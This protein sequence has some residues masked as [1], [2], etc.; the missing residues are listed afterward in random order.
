M[1]EAKRNEVV[2]E[3]AGFKIHQR[4]EYI[5][6]KGF[7]DFDHGWDYPDGSWHSLLPDLL[8]DLNALFKWPVWVLREMGY[9]VTIVSS[10]GEECHCSLF[11][12]RIGQTGNAE[13]PA[14]AL[15]NA[16]EKLVL[17]VKPC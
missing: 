11:K 3:F 17:E 8:R 13:D 16:I 2:A 15:F 9:E 14:A 6:G 10:P 7:E 1:K 5:R 4:R 12:N